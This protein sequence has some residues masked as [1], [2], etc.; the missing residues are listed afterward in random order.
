MCI[1]KD[2]YRILDLSFIFFQFSVQAKCDTL[3]VYCIVMYTEAVILPL[4]YTQKYF[5]T[6]DSCLLLGR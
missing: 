5:L 1:H 6:L 4:K 2:V 3:N